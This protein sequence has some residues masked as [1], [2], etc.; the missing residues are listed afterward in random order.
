[1][2]DVKLLGGLK[3]VDLGVG[4]A[5]ALVA[6]FL[7]DA[8]AQVTRVPPAGGDPFAGHYAAYEVWRRGASVDA[9]ASDSA[10][11]LEQLLA[12]ADVCVIGGEDH[13]EIARRRDAGEIAARHPRLVVL[14][15]TDGPEGT[16]YAGRPLTELTAQARSGLSWEQ[17]PERPIVNAF[18]PGNY[19]AALQG[20]IGV[21]AALYE[22]EGSGKGQLVTTSLFE[23]ALAWIGTYWAQ[24]EKPTPAADYVIP[25]GVWPLV[26]RAKDGVYIHLVIGAPGSKYGMYKALEIDDPTVKP[27]DVSMPQ[28]GAG[29]KNFFGDFD[30]LAE[31]V[32]K[33]DS[34]ELLE[35]IWALGLPAEPVLAPGEC[36]SEA[37]IER[38]GVLV[39]NADGT[40]HVG[41]PFLYRTTPA[42]V[43]RKAPGKERPLEGVKVVDC[44][45]FVAGP[46][47]SVILADLGA[48]VV[49]VEAKAGDPNRAIFKSFTKAN[50][51]KK[52]LAADHKDPD[53][54]A[55]VQSLCRDADVVMSNFRPG[56]AERLGIGAERLRAQNPGLIVLESPAYG[57][58]GPLA[59]KSGFDMVMQAWC[60][61]EAK[62]AG[63]GNPP[64]WNRTNLADI[65]A[66]MIGAVALLSALVHR[67]RTG[68][69]VTLESPLV[70]AGLFTLSELIQRPDGTFAGVPTLSS[71]LAGYHPAEALY[72][73]KNGWVALVA[74]GEKA[75]LRL[76]SLLKLDDVLSA[77]VS[78]WDEA[79]EKAIAA[80]VAHFTAD[81]LAAFLEPE[82]IW[83]EVCR[84]DREK[85]I[86]NDRKLLA[87]GTVRAVEHP[88]FGVIRELAAMFKLSRSATGNVRPAPLLGGA[89]REILAAQ[90]YD[91]ARIEDLMARGVTLQ[92]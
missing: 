29:A 72:R 22:R 64:R 50:R 55:V 77:S 20:L 15:I 53:G 35:A 11:R 38:N 79:A 31:H 41:L 52:G 85:A 92:A 76:R 27:T 81:E 80:A 12:D 47:A 73:T 62:A 65:A 48:E 84:E 78:T 4:M 33:K 49:K 46:L 21:L 86:L 90:G 23:G 68:N 26:F 28:P 71:T 54:N 40:R 18:E 9:S 88:K 44:G 17:D 13:P 61:H 87:R 3:V 89:T 37:Q 30:L 57:S 1:M 36:W 24:L 58:E 19:G 91:D 82:G 7:A 69:A 59:E 60:G 63:R 51:G 75:A 10:E 25:R 42:D 67:A 83:V 2:Q 8:G 66:G 70:N 74:R 6:K 43:A 16:D 5:P 39:K 32:A 56:V 45:A 14:D 34:K